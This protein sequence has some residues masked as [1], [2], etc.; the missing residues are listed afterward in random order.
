MPPEPERLGDHRARHELKLIIGAGA[1]ADN[2]H[3]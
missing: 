3:G 2:L 1:S